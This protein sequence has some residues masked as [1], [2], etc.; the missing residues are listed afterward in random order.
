MTP[1]ELKDAIIKH[2]FPLQRFCTN[3]IH[4]LGGS[5]HEEYPVQQTDPITGSV[6][7][8]IFK[9]RDIRTS[10]DLRATFDFV[11]KGFSVHI[12]ISCKRK[13][14]QQWVFMPAI[15]TESHH[16]FTRICKRNGKPPVGGF[17]YM[18]SSRDWSTA[19]PLCNI[20]I[21]IN[22]KP[23]GEERHDNHILKTSDNLYFEWMQTYEDDLRVFTKTD[24]PYTQIIYIPVIVTAADLYVCKLEGTSFKVDDSS[25]L[26]IEEV[27]YLLYLHNL[28]SSLQHLM[29]N[30][31]VK[32]SD[33]ILDKFYI[34][35][36]NY[37]S[38]ANFIESLLAFFNKQ[39][40]TPPSWW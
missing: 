28:P 16:L 2:G 8:Q 31:G 23:A 34:F 40:I 20:P 18:F 15:Y 21:D 27:P 4:N 14:N 37:K 22:T 9:P 26:K 7:S 3:T 13:L 19:Y 1:E 30:S 11:A 5:V 29:R 24:F 10:G 39:P 36:V 12:P 6:N 32:D 25:L 33:L 38:L 17:D 35:V